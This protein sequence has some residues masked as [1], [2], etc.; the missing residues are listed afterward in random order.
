MI[1]AITKHH[2]YS[3]GGCLNCEPIGNESELA[4]LADV[5]KATTSAFFGKKQFGGHRTIQ[6]GSHDTGK[7]VAALKLLNG[8]IFA[9]PSVRRKPP[10]QAR[11]RRIAAA[12][13]IVGRPSPNTSKFFLLPAIAG[14]PQRSGTNCQ[15]LGIRGPNTTSHRV[16]EPHR[17]GER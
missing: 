1:G 12:H 14:I 16:C 3:D 5:D 4:R 13:W 15:L 2:Q 6:D 11:T 17:R 10:K 9:N 7:L 8:E